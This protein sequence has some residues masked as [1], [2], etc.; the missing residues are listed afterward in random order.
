MTRVSKDDV[1]YD[2][3]IFDPRVKFSFDL[4]CHTSM[5]EPPLPRFEWPRFDLPELSFCKSD[6]IH[7]KSVRKTTYE[8]KKKA[9][10]LLMSYVS[11]ATHTQQRLQKKLNKRKHI[12]F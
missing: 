2:D 3:F 5:S 7:N 1:E 8:N 11:N 6:C 10:K 4:E 12:T 9:E